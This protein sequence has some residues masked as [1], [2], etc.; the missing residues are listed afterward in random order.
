MGRVFPGESKSKHRRRSM[1]KMKGRT[2]GVARQPSIANLGRV[3]DVQGRGRGRRLPYWLRP[4]ED[5]EH[6]TKKGS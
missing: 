4:H 5:L 2:A 3:Q 1:R 6:P